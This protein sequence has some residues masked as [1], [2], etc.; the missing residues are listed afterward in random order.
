MAANFAQNPPGRLTR[1]Y[2]A[3]ERAVIDPF[4]TQYM[5]TT[6]AAA[7]KTIAQVHILPALFNHWDRIGEAVSG[8]DMRMRTMVCVRI[9]LFISSKL[10][11]R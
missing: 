6:S 5:A 4:K 2:N 10:Q 11:G 1:V 3:Q 8:N 7:R 9:R